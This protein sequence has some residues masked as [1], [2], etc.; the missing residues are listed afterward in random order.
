MT[1]SFDEDAVLS[2]IATTI[3]QGTTFLVV[4]H[5]SPDGDAVASTLAMSN[6]LREMGKEVLAFNADL[7]PQKLRFLPG[8]DTMSTQLDAQIRYDVGI[9]LDA[10]ELRRTQVDVPGICTQSIN[11]DHHPHSEDFGDIY[12]VDTSASATAVLI[13]RILQHMCHPVSFA[14]AENIYT[15]IISDTGS[16]RY[17]SANSEAFFVAGE[18]VKIGVDPWKIA[19]GLYESQEAE[20]LRLLAS[21]LATLQVSACGRVA[22]MHTT[23]QM[24]EAAGASSELAD[25]FVNYPRSIQGVEVAI[26]LRELA[27]DVFKLGMRSKG[28]VDVGQ[29][30]RDLHGGGHHNAAGAEMRGSLEQ[31]VAELFDRLQPLLP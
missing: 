13:F 5:E 28:K 25:S 8:A 7:V 31:I 23:Q 14:V 10:G 30:A 3:R 9:V 19:G 29:L 17:S 16:F 4:A 18:M 2:R 26:F 15:A 22:V 1:P 27:P 20:R 24:F 21:A 12:Y 6:A 11:I